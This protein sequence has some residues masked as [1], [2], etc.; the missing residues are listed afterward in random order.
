MNTFDSFRQQ[1]KDS[2]PSIFTKEDVVSLIDKMEKEIGE[3]GREGGSFD[4]E[5]FM[6]KV[7]E[8]LVQAFDSMSGDDVVDFGSAEFY[9]IGRE[10]NLYSVAVEIYA[11]K[12]VATEAIDI[13]LDEM[14]FTNE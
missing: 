2:Y 11:L 1:V 9:L 10:V 12:K 13:T 6:E 8:K 3:K 7:T 4:R 14:G 5:A